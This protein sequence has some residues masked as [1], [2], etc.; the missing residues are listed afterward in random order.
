MREKYLHFY[1]FST[2]SKL[3]KDTKKCRKKWR[4]GLKESIKLML[5]IP[6]QL[7]FLKDGINL[8][9]RIHICY[10]PAGRSVLGE[11]VSEVLSTARGRRP[12]EVLRPR[13]QFLTI[14]TD[15]GRWITFLFFSYWDLKVSGKFYFSLQT[16]CVE[17]G[18]VP[19]DVIQS[20]RSIT[21]QNKTLQHDF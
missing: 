14:R 16:M 17:E 9:Q 12:R 1:L 3:Q 20:A 2:R 5:F 18:R 13:A 4:E 19:V 21:N 10:S 8:R 6:S 11:T 15:L 7:Q